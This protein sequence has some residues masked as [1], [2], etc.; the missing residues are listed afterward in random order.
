MLTC[1][2][3]A[4]KDKADNKPKVVF[5]LSTFHNPFMVDTSKADRDE[6]HIMK[7]AMVRSYNVHMGGVDH[8]GQQLHGIQA[9]RKPY[10]WYKKLIFRLFLQIS[11]NSDKVYQK[12]AGSN[13][14]FLDYLTNNIKL[15][16]ALTRPIPPAI[17]YAIP[18]SDV[19]RCRVCYSQKKST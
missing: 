16:I 6:E 19:E 12:C 1:K 18:Q 2:Y 15:M 5:M 3:R 7:P 9:L 17:N 10:K 14:V 8:G 11:L 13:M 4:S